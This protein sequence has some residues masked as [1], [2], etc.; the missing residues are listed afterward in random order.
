MEIVVKNLP[1]LDVTMKSRLLVVLDFIIFSVCFLIIVVSQQHKNYLHKSWYHC[2]WD[3]W[4][5]SITESHTLYQP[6]ST[7]DHIDGIYDDW[8]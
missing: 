1:I 4:F 5:T 7:H 6:C 8:I 2:A 3:T